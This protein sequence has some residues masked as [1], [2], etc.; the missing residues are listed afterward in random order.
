MI[1]MKAKK[2]TSVQKAT[3]AEWKARTNP[4]ES[5][6]IGQVFSH[7]KESGLYRAMHKLVAQGLIKPG[8]PGGNPLK[9]MA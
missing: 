6:M 9:E 4:G 3:L 8:I 7:A 2:L 1:S 5:Y